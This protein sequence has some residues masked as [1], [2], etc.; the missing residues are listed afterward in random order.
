MLLFFL[1]PSLFSL[2]YFLYNHIF[3]FFLL[4]HFCINNNTNNNNNN[5]QKKL[6]LIITHTHTH[7]FSLL[8]NPCSFCN[9]NIPTS[10]HSIQHAFH[11]HFFFFFFFCIS[12]SLTL[13]FF[14]LF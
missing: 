7:T 12:L 9:A 10:L 13:F 5:T 1:S 8:F 3:H 14:F 4:S 6:L 11:F 2:L